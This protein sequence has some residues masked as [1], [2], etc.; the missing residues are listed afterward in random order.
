MFNAIATFFSAAGKAVVN[1]IQ[2]NYATGQKNFQN[3][4]SALKEGDI[5]KLGSKSSR[6]LL[7]NMKTA[8]AEQI[9][10]GQLLA[11]LQN[12]SR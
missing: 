9:D 10:A 3:T 2:K 11:N 5:T 4:F 6:P 7:D 12:M 1:N 8:Q